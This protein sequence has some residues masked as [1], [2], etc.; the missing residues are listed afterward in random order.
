MSHNQDDRERECGEE[1][2]GAIQNDSTLLQVLYR[3]GIP[4]QGAQKMFP[5]SCPAKQI[6]LMGQM[7]GEWNQVTP[8]P[9]G[10][11]MFFYSFKKL[12]RLGI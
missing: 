4:P 9:L 7:F 6:F 5:R 3:S 1:Q 11:H 2:S 12:L 10:V 8:I